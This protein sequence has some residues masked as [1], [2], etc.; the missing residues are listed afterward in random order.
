MLLLLIIAILNTFALVEYGYSC[1][2][3]TEAE[4][5]NFGMKL[6]HALLE[7]TD[8]F[9]PHMKEEEEKT[10]DASRIGANTFRHHFP[11][12]NQKLHEFDLA[13]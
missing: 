2:S 3:K 4:R 12:I 11:V 1:S 8:S 10:G 13:K 5:I 9:L 6:Q 7:F